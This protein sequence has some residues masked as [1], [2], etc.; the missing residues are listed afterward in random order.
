MLTIKHAFVI[1]TAASFD[2]VTR[3]YVALQL[4]PAHN[5]PFPILQLRKSNF[6]SLGRAGD[7]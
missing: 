2:K 6:L 1:K 7:P 4:I 3:Q 5:S